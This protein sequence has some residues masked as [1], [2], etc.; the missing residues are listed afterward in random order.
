[1]SET[2]RFI[3][4]CC[5]EEHTGLPD[6]GFDAQIYY[7][8]VPAEEREAR[9]RLSDDFFVLDDSY[10]F[11]RSVLLIPIKQISESFG[12]GLWTSL[13]K[14][15]FQRYQEL[16]DAESP[17]D[18][19]PYFGW[20][21]NKLPLYPDTMNLKVAVHLQ[22]RGNRPL[23]ELEPTAH[24]LAIDQREGITQERAKEIVQSLLH[25]A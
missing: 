19:G 4:E 10:Y 6:Y 23:L 13:S 24:P 9:C 5:G 12:W 2:F 25:R 18:E 3:C 14:Q 8:E 11:V 16:W 15:N 17:G 1:M 20:L 7:H 22:D 21:S